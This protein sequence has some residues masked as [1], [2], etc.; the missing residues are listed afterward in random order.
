M[1]NDLNDE[2][3]KP[4]DGMCCLCTYE[5]ISEEAGNYVEYQ[6]YPSM[7]WSPALFEREI[8]ESLVNSQF[9]KY[10]ETV[11]KS[12]C[13]AELRR[14]LDQGPPIYV[15]DKV[16]LPLP[17]GDEYVMKLWFAHDGKER[18]AKLKGALEGKER[19]N[20]WNELKLYLI[21]DEEDPEE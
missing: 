15:S 19:D 16:A 1:S 4:S 8:V 6:S 14:L 13:Q 12:D 10:V 9:E 21:K 3:G 2:H 7:K 20:L 17:E 5:D 11:K 18:S